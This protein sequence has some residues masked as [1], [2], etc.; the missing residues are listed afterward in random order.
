MTNLL[1]TKR[2][3]NSLLYEY[4]SGYHVLGL[5]VLA[6]HADR[7]RVGADPAH[8]GVARARAPVRGRARR[9]RRRRHHRAHLRGRG[10]HMV[11]LRRSH[12]C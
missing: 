5:P 4:F 2:T 10:R 8:P 11:G 6:V 1:R 7:D 3:L 9:R 12:T